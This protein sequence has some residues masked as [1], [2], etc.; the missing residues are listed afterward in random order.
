M[1]NDEIK[2]MCHDDRQDPYY[3]IKEHFWKCEYRD[4]SEIAN[5]GL[6]LQALILG[7]NVN[8]DSVNEAAMKVAVYHAF[9]V[10]FELVGGAL[11]V[12]GMFLET[13]IEC[14]YGK[15]AH[16]IAPVGAEKLLKMAAE[17]EKEFKAFLRKEFEDSKAKRVSA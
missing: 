1:T 15:K 3:M 16:S 11:G 13:A 10:A 2:A 8:S 9:K 7:E 17:I 12:R 6:R 5:E 4:W 14:L